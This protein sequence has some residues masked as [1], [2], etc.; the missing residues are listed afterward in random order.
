MVDRYRP[1]SG[2][3]HLK[4]RFHIHALNALGNP[5]QVIDQE[6][7]ASGAGGWVFPV[8]LE[9]QLVIGAHHYHVG[10]FLN[11]GDQAFDLANQE[12]AEAPQDA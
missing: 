10:P 7:H 3:R 2:H 9:N 8:F 1:V 6:A 11:E 5:R 4:F 12:A